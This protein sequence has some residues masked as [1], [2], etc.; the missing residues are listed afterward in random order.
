M[1]LPAWIWSP[2]FNPWLHQNVYA[3]AELDQTDALAASQNVANILP[4]NDPA[5]Q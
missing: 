1:S 2:T 5:S 3:R 4:E